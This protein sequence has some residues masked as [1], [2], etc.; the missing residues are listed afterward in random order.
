MENIIFDTGQIKTVDID[1]VRPNTWNPK[2]RETEEYKTIKRGIEL[3]GLRQPIFVRQNDGYEIVDGEQRWSACTELGYKR[4]LIYDLGEISKKE[5]QELT[6]WFEQKVPFNEIDLAHL[7]ADM[8]KSGEK[9]EIPFDEVA[10]E[11]YLKMAEFDFDSYK[12]NSESEESMDQ[13][14]IAV[15]K[16]TLDQKSIIDKAI[17]VV[18]EDKPDMTDGRALE[19][20]SADFLSGHDSLP[21]PEPAS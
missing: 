17:A 1:Q 3:K 10:L 20:I 6:L 12:T 8:V 16:V 21:D 5:A 7:L 13:D 15:Y 2:D 9:L 14:D 4:I 11:N 19:L 18:R